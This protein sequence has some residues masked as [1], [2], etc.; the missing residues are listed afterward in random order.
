MGQ[1][2]LD[3][4]ETID[5][6][7]DGVQ[8]RFGSGAMGQSAKFSIFADFPV[9][10]PVDDQTSAMKLASLPSGQTTRIERIVGAAGNLGAAQARDLVTLRSTRRST[11]RAAIFWSR[12]ATAPRSQTNLRH[13][14]FGCLAIG[15]CRDGPI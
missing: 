2:L 5:V 4:L 3:Y 7:D 12:R 1:H 6:E 9:Q 14:W 13:I 8:S 10:S 15:Y 11:W